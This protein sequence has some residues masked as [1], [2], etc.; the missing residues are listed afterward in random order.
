MWKFFVNLA[1]SLL[2]TAALF[3]QDP[4]VK[5]YA[6]DSVAID[7]AAKV[8]S[9][10]VGSVVRSISQ[11]D[12]ETSLTRSMSELLLEASALQIKSMGQGALSTVS[13]RGTSSTHT[14]V[15]WNGISINSPQMGGFDFSQLPVYFTDNVDLHYGGS[16]VDGGSGAL[17]GSVAFANSSHSVDK[18]QL[19]ITVEGAS[20]DTYTGA[21]SLRFTR[22]R[23]TSSTRGYYQQSDNDYR[24]LNNVF[25]T[26]AFYERRE[27]A[28]YKQFGL[29]QELYY[30]APSDHN[31]SLIAW[32]QSDDR[33]LPQSILGNVVVDETSATDN[34]R[35]LAS[36][37]M[38]RPDFELKNSIAF[39]D[40]SLDY[41]K[42]MSGT[43]LSQTVNDNTSAIATSGLQYAGFE[44]FEL[45]AN[46]TY[47]YDKVASDSYDDGSKD[48]NTLLARAY[49]AVRLT[50]R[51]TLDAQGTLEQMDDQTSAI[52]SVSGRYFA[53]ERLLTIKVSNSYNHRNPSLNDLYWSPGGNPDLLP[54]TGFSWDLTL[55]SNPSVGLLDLDLAATYYRM[56]IENWIMWIPEGNG[57]VWQPVNYSK[58]FSQGVEL[59]AQANFETADF[60]HKLSANYTYAQS[61]DNTNQDG[62][63]G[64]QLAYI[65]KNRFSA[66]YNL[67]YKGRVWFS[68][69]LIFT[70]VRFTTAD[71]SYWTNAY[72]LH[73]AELGY[74]MKFAGSEH[75]L[76]LSVRAENIF[77]SYYEST[78]YYPMPLRMIW[79]RAS[80]V[81][82][83]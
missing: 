83:P 64:K 74:K 82:N 23:L 42:E 36:H 66:G 18:P 67:W 65:P 37:Q 5:E 4:A 63:H 73:N 71:E 53:I 69:D 28:D 21:L 13:F 48:R 59:M 72:T 19:S 14:Q 29:M 50:P 32:Y 22:G 80:L 10:T 11:A 31:I 79:L 45:G 78:Q 51:L 40:G 17:G 52:Y 8:A 46:L 2:A 57:Y 68:Y 26:E 56:N 15:L 34:L 33:S 30:S 12:I 20:N 58:V 54:E 24:Y 9:G 27:N 3:A 25:S 41:Q 44:A 61:V 39:L 7:G 49:G 77:D 1:F 70:D 60:T 55:E 47:R 6:I 38:S 62:S 76:N 43:P 35:I 16:L 75:G 81:F